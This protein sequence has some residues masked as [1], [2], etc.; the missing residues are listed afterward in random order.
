MTRRRPGPAAW[1]TCAT[2]LTALAGLVTLAEGCANLALSADFGISGVGDAA[3]NG[4]D[5]GK[6]DS[7]GLTPPPSIDS[8]SDAGT[9]AAFAGS[10]L[11]GIPSG[12]TLCDPDQA[13]A[14]DAGEYGACLAQAVPVVDSGPPTAMP[15]GG[16]SEDASDD[17]AFPD[18]ATPGPS[19]DAGVP[20]DS[21]VP[22]P[23]YSPLACHV[24]PQGDGGVSPT[25][26]V[27]GTG[28]D[29][30]YCMS[31]QDCAPGFECVGDPG[32]GVCRHYCCANTCG[33]PPPDGGSPTPL[34]DAGVP[35]A[36]CDIEPLVNGASAPSTAVPVCVQKPSCTL[37]E[38]CTDPMQTCTIVDS[39]GTT[40]CITAGSQDVGQSCEYAHC[41]A[42]LACWGVF[43]S[44]A[45]VQICDATHTCPAP[46]VCQSN[47]TNFAN[48]SAGL[49]ICAVP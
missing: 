10:P 15:D 35:P 33:A 12:G 9:A 1:L 40:A 16:S 30:A 37:L 22:A 43:P 38:P 3:V 20:Y 14:P 42:G 28:A 2:A 8:A 47:D 17:D 45:C 27:A 46:Q 7:A 39:S 44:R 49:G 31:G 21:S 18:D 5:Q 41:K 29:G 4:G 32:H 11:C 6:S 48:S 13:E 23:V 36:F 24:V 26:T 25:C 34:V 19:P